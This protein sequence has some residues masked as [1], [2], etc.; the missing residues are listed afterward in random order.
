[1]L[2]GSQITAFAL[3]LASAFVAITINVADAAQTGVGAASII[4]ESELG[5]PEP[6]ERRCPNPKK[7]PPCPPK[8]CTPPSHRPPI[9]ITRPELINVT[10]TVAIE[11]LEALK[12]SGQATGDDYLL[13]GYFY[14]LEGQYDLSEVN[15]LK[16]SEL[17][18]DTDKKALAEQELKEI[19]AAK[20]M[21]EAPKY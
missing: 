7:C 19:R 2:K 11:K 1:M 20:E 4:N 5:N 15:Y 10:S 13:L 17:A 14:S 6:L 18:T 21:E 9:E 3:T 8:G 12:T 16:A